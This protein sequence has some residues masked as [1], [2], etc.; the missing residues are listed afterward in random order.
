MIFTVKS[1]SKPMAVFYIMFDGEAVA[2]FI[3]WSINLTEKLTTEATK[4]HAMLV[5]CGAVAIGTG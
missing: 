2:A 4:L 1:I 3:I 5:S